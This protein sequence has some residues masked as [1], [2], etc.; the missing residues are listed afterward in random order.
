MRQSDIS[1]LE[2]VSEYNFGNRGTRFGPRVLFSS[3]GK[4]FISSLLDQQYTMCGVSFLFFLTYFLLS[5]ENVVVCCQ[6]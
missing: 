3:F 1:T 5:H 2:W 6:I 4:H